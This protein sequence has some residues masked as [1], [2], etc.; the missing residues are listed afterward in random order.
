MK[1]IITL[2]FALLSIIWLSSCEK[3]VSENTNTE[4]NTDKIN[5]EI[6]E[7]NTENIEVLEVETESEERVK[8][9]KELEYPERFDAVTW[10]SL[11]KPM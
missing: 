8:S 11:E 7:N 3:T 6:N 9:E 5:E 4:T 1:K 10:E 2:V